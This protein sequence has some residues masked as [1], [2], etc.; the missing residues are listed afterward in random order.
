MKAVFTL[1]KQP[2]DQGLMHCGYLSHFDMAV[3]TCLAVETARQYYHEIELVTDDSGKQLL[4]D[5]LKLPFSSV[6][7]ALNNYSH[8]PVQ[9]WAYP[10]MVAYSVQTRPF[11]HLDNDVYLWDGLPSDIKNKPLAFQNIEISETMYNHYRHGIGR[12]YASNAHSVRV[13]HNYVPHAFN[14]GVVMANDIEFVQEW[15]EAAKL[16]VE[17]PENQWMWENRDVLNSANHNLVFEQ[18][19]PACLAKQRG[20][21]LDRDIGF[22]LLPYERKGFRFTHTLGHVK[23]EK[24]VAERVWA[25][26]KHQYPQYIK[27]LEDLQPHFMPEPR[28][29]ELLPV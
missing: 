7:L 6:N 29:K 4:C 28:R 21:E 11:V 2:M 15:W 16:Y 24:V 20:L 22:V 9:H 1:W 26:V 13:A 27:A 14:C 25:R 10:K 17:H 18:W 3:S 23:R 5:H 19:F 8:I 12:F